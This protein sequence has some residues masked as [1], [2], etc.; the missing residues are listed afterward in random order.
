MESAEVPSVDN[1][2]TIVAGD[3]L[4]MGTYAATQVVDG[5]RTQGD[6][7]VFGCF[8]SLDR[9]RFLGRSVPLVQRGN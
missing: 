7:A 1:T 3:W 4:D 6:F 8:S 2:I 9:I 5:I